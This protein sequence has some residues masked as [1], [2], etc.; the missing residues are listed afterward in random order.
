MRARRQRQF[1]FRLAAAEMQMVFVVRDRTVQ[2]RQV[3]VD[4]EVKVSGV[5]FLDSGR[6]DAHSIEPKMDRGLRTNHRA[7]LEI[8]ELGIRA[9]R[10]RSRASSLSGLGVGGRGENKASE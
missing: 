10:R 8:D 9:R 7:V 4:K 5:R 1:D 3:R 6:R 2:G